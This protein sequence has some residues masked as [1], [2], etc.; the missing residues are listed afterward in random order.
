MANRDYTVETRQE[1][2][3]GC[4]YR[5]ASEETGVGIYMVGGEGAWMPCDRMPW[6]LLDDEG[7]PIKHFRGL[8][9]INPQEFFAD[10]KEPIKA[11]CMHA[12]VVC[13]LGGQ[14]QPY[15]LIHFV[16]KEH[17]TIEEFNR[18]AAARGISRRV[19][20]LPDSFVPGVT[21]VYLAH[22]DACDWTDPLTGET[23]KVPGIFKVFRPRIELVIDNPRDVPDK[24]KQLKDKYGDQA[25]IVKVIPV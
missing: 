14:R 15:G 10:N 1:R 19:G 11:A 7:A 22:M 18:E 2:A 13:P 8:K 12:C 6:P 9:G 24:A 23:K 20:Q 21:W 17:Y 5:H 4:G 3:R 16:G 25:T